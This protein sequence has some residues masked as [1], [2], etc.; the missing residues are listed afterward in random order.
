MALALG[1]R[2][3]LAAPV[4]VACTGSSSMAGTGSSAGHHIPDELAKALGPEFAVTNFAVA[5]TTAIKSVPNAWASTP[6]MSDALASNPDVVLFW[7]GGNDSWADVWSA[8]GDEFKGDYTSI[9]QAFQALPSHPKTILIR[10]W[11]FKDGPAQLSVLD[12]EILPTIAAIAAETG[13]TVIDYRSFMEPHP[14]WFP[15]GMHAS[16]TG[17]P[18]IGAFFAEQVKAALNGSGGAGGAGGAAGASGFAGSAGAVGLGGAGGVSGSAGSAGSGEPTLAGGG[19]ATEHAAPLAG[20]GGGGGTSGNG[21]AAGAPSSPTS[22]LQ[23]GASS[24][25][26]APV[27]EDGASCSFGRAPSGG[28]V[29]ALL[30]ALFLQRFRRRRSA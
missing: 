22:S 23:A 19:G 24:K 6:Q 8:H 16:D 25:P 20:A 4:K 17:T 29:A 14:D 28:S 18:F 15:D 7:F 21:A 27:S 11:V 13:S 2:P 26:S 1:G 10:L 9:V 3:V 30:A 12:Q 5:A